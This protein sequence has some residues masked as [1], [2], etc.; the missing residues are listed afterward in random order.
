MDSLAC[1]G[2]RA[3]SLQVE[4]Q[5]NRQY[6]SMFCEFAKLQLRVVARL[7]HVR[8]RLTEDSRCR[9]DL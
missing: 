1:F 2:E 6:Y 4:R 7:Q 3:A 8:E 9:L 5:V